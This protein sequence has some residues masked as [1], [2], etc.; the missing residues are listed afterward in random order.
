MEAQKG[1]EKWKCKEWEQT[2]RDCLFFSGTNLS[3]FGHILNTFRIHFRH[4]LQSKLV[5]AVRQC[6]SKAK[7]DCLWEFDVQFLAARDCV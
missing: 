2:G 4:S 3:I 7:T 6:Q 1:G 5:A